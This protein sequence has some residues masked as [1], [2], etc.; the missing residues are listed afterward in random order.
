MSGLDTSRIGFEMSRREQKSLFR[1]LSDLEKRIVFLEETAF[2]DGIPQEA[3]EFIDIPTDASE[4]KIVLLYAPG[5]EDSEE[6]IE[7]LRA[8]LDTL[9]VGYHPTNKEPK[10]REILNEAL[11]EETEQEEK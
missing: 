6:T 11:S 9:G 5:F 7:D 2:P 1:A 8:Q 10:L 4:K 3:D